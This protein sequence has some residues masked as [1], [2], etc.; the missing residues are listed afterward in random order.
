MASIVNWARPSY[1]LKL[2]S[3]CCFSWKREYRMERALPLES[4]GLCCHSGF[5]HENE[6][7]THICTFVC[8]HAYKYTC[9]EL[10]CCS[11]LYFSCWTLTLHNLMH[12]C[13][14]LWWCPCSVKLS[15]LPV[16][17]PAWTPRLWFPSSCM[18]SDWSLK[19]APLPSGRVLWN[20]QC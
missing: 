7:K 4:A 11:S 6:Q 13:L 19:D 18:L 12:V 9:T 2:S 3:R 5:G 1:V 20:L 10:E 8:V 15:P 16:L 14:L 17:T